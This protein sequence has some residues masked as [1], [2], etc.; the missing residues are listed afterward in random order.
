VDKREVFNVLKMDKKKDSDSMN[1]V[2]LNN[3]GEGVIHKI[4]MDELWKMIEQ[5]K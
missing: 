4:P 5:C 1:Y 2:L 3:F